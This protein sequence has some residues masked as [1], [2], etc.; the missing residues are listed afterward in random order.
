MTP[1]HNIPHL[2]RSRLHKRRATFFSVVLLTTLAGVWLMLDFLMHTG[3]GLNWLEVGMILVFTPLFYQLVTGFWLAVMGLFVKMTG[4]KDPLDLTHSLKPEDAEL[5]LNGSVGIIMPVYNEDVTRVFEGLRVIYQSLEKTGHLKN[6]DFFV[7]SDSD[8]PNKW[9]EEET[10]WLALCKQLNAFGK[11]FYRKRRKPINRKSGNVS[12]FCRR[13]GKRYRYMLVLDADSVMSGDT[14]V[15][16]TRIMD[17]HP[18]IG[19]LQTAPR[20]FGAETLFGRVMQF[21]GAIYGGPFMS[22]LNYM[23]MGDAT[24]WGHNAIIRLAPFIEFCALPELPGKEP[25][26]GRILSHD[27]VEAALM[28]KA[29]WFVF[30]LPVQ[31]G[32]YEE[33]PPTL[34]DTLKR[35][36]RW[37]QGNMQHIWLL[38]AKGWKP[39]S[40]LNFLHG[41]LSYV[42]SPLW[43]AFLVFATVLA[44]LKGY[45]DATQRLS[46]M[47]LLILTVILLF[48]PKIA[49]M[50]TEMCRRDV[51]REYGGRLKV[52]GGCLVDTFFFSLLAPILMV[53][54]SK[55]VLFTFAGKGVKWAA[56]RRKS[57]DSIDWQESIQNFAGITILAL[58]WMAIAI[59]LNPT[60]FFWILPVLLGMA[61][62]IPFSIVT[63]SNLW[64]QKLFFTR[65]EIDKPQVIAQMQENFAKAQQRS[66]PLTRLADHYGLLQAVLDPYINA[67]HVGLLR[68][69]QRTTPESKEYLESLR[70]K[71]LREGPGALNPR[72]VK[73]LMYDP[74]IMLRLHYDLW[75]STTQELDPWWDLAIR[76]YNILTF[77]PTTPLA[78]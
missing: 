29:G 47:I 62:A 71:I 56:Q 1:V 45:G 36:R 17:K 18:A 49:I 30:L 53:F 13:W 57:D 12:D 52:L 23:Q 16:M 37:C 14:M 2:T 8:S 3:A 15:Q 25:F 27:F 11:I 77:E 54:H 46:G 5:P 61:L 40:R 66:K 43:F 39:I 67:L 51:A 19:I 74:D 60:F 22:G 42:S 7:L 26:G 33:G 6:F 9:I 32:S 68:Q 20:V 31:E 50:L 24:F 72:E 41:I 76:Q 75:S 38:F 48:L 44:G 28:R 55:F 4:D 70:K 78:Q 34:L 59:V 69:R 65:E 63:S 35:D 58:I 73:A 10:A 21:A 64:R